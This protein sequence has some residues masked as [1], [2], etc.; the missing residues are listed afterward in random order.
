MFLLPGVLLLQNI[1]WCILDETLDK[2]GIKTILGTLHLDTKVRN[3]LTSDSTSRISSPA[4][5]TSFHPTISVGK[6]GEAFS[7]ILPFSSYITRTLAQVSPATKMQP[8]LRLPLW[9]MAVVTGLGSGE[10]QVKR[11]M[12]FDLIFTINGMF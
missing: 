6:P 1:F 11:K 4:A 9:I 3:V 2:H 12:T 10:R 8:F 7:M 5:G